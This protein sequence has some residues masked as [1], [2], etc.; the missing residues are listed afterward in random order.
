MRRHLI[1]TACVAAALS[2]T[3]AVAEPLA[4]CDGIPQTALITVFDGK[5]ATAVCNEMLKVL[6]QPT[7]DDLIYFEKAAYLLNAQGYSKDY[8]TITAELVDVIRLRGLYDKRPRWKETV[9]L[10]YRTY[11]AFHGAVTPEVAADFLEAAGPRAMTW[12]DDRFVKTMVAARIRYLRG[13]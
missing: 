8:A 5:D 1:M 3:A 2:G 10:L 6:D 13:E 7:T 12:S 4:K 11:V 9:E